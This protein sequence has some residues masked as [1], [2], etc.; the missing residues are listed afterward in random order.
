VRDE[1]NKAV[2]AVKESKTEW[3]WWSEKDYCKYVSYVRGLYKD[4]ES[5]VV[6][7]KSS[8]RPPNRICMWKQHRLPI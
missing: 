1:H 6:G 7:R 3:M 4:V 8:W 2:E 5:D